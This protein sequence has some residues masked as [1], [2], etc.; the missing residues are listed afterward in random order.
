MKAHC[1]SNT[2]STH[3]HLTP[4]GPGLAPKAP[5]AL[6]CKMATIAACLFVMV[7]TSGCAS[8]KVSDRQQLVTGHIPRPSI[9]LVY[10]FAA[11]PSD[12]PADSAMAGMI[13]YSAGPQTAEDI[14]IG[15]RLGAQIASDLAV[16]IRAMGMPAYSPSPGVQPQLNDIVIRGY[17]VSI[18]EGNAAQRVIVGFG[19]GGSSLRTVVEGFQMTPQGLRKIGSG[20][21]DAGGNKT[22]GAALGAA[23]FIATANPAG[24]IVSSG[25]KVYGEASGNSKVEGRAKATAKEIAKVLKQ[26]FEQQGWI[27]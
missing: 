23:T 1:N 8:T 26:R 12:V 15:R 19:R 18:E 4:I 24:L 17:L 5:L 20:M 21:V 7:V 10:D 27:N 16:R 25:M 2:V 9:I 13:D 6:W 3:S 14:A 22:P 11:T